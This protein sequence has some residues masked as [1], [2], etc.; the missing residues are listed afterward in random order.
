VSESAEG[1][2]CSLD[3]YRNYLRLLATWQLGFRFRS[4]LDPSDVVQDTLLAAIAKQEQFQGTSQAEQAA[5][6]RT[7]LANRLA[8]EIRRWQTEKRDVGLER[9]L[10]YDLEASS[11]RLEVWLADAASSPS[12]RAQRH[13]NL[14]VLANA[15][16][17]L[18]E[19]QR[20]AIE[21]H[22]LNGL[23]VSE[24]ARQMQRTEFSVAGLL[25]RGLKSLRMQLQ[26]DDSS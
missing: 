19:D 1:D 17:H 5:W 2:L 6:L 26:S 15:L 16:M 3:D 25:R 23:S 7:I 21:L 8:D 4:K 20:A 13:D 12:Q 14:L 18:P 9:S 10:E 22:H 24:V 11:S